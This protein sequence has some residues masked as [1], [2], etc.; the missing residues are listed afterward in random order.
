MENISLFGNTREADFK[1]GLGR[2]GVCVCVCVCAC[3]YGNYLSKDVDVF[4]SI[5]GLLK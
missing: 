1:F 4:L 5:G 2:E 3:H